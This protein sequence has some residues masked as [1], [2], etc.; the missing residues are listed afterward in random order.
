MG[1]ITDVTL[2]FSPKNFELM[3]PLCAGAH[4]RA[5]FVDRVDLL[6]RCQVLVRCVD[7]VGIGATD[8]RYRKTRGALMA[9]LES[10]FRRSVVQKWYEKIL[11]AL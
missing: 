3:A 9:L 2:F 5:A 6:R 7:S 11:L 4:I 8:I 1:K 10:W